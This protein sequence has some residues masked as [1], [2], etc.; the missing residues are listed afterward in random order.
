[1]SQGNGTGISTG[2][3]IVHSSTVVTERCPFDENHRVRLKRESL[4]KVDAGGPLMHH[5]RREFYC[6]E[7]GC[8][9]RFEYRYVVNVLPGKA[10]DDD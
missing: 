5:V 6:C 10:D 7:P 2:N 9:C 3:R 4:L 1:M 8:G